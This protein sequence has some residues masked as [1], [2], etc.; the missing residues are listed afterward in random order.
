MEKID[1]LNLKEMLS[2]LEKSLEEKYGYSWDFSSEICTIV[3]SII[4]H[5]GIE[6][7]R[8][9]IDAIKECKI[10]ILQ[11]KENDV[12]TIKYN[13]GMYI[14]LPVIDKGVISK[15]NK[16]IIL[17]PNYNME[18]VSYRG[19]LLSQILKLIRSCENE[20]DIANGTLIQREGL[21]Q[22]TYKLK[23]DN[24]LE[25]VSNVGV[26]YEKGSLDNATLNI[27]R[28]NFDE[29]F[30]LTSGNDYERLLTGYLEDSLGLKETFDK[31]GLT[32][33]FGELKSVLENADMSLDEFLLKID[34]L[35]ELE[36][37]RKKSTDDI[38][39]RQSIEGLEQYYSHELTEM[40]SK[41][42]Q[43]LKEKNLAKV[44]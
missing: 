17:P 26:G 43:R 30:E 3:E 9:V 40:I 37:K 32:G 39:Q 36:R 11:K 21:A 22:T 16:K 7:A 19:V 10:E 23:D 28:N 42:E 27:M 8:I 13:G 5:Y 6:Y 4:E 12:S 35:E 44:M 31:A 1:N 29:N 15:V 25:S 41:I 24:S 14:S 33:D 18:S 38:S 20:F 34:K 2:T